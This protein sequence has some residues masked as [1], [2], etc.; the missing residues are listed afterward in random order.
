MSFAARDERI[1]SLM[2]T[3]EA[4]I[5]V[6]KRTTTIHN[7]D[8]VLGRS[9]IRVFAGKTGYIDE[10]GHCFASLVADPVDGRTK[11]VVVLG[12]NVRPAVFAETRHLLRWATASA[13]RELSPEETE[14]ALPTVE[15]ALPSVDAVVAAV[16]AAKLAEIPVVE[17]IDRGVAIATIAPEATQLAEQPE[18]QGLDVERSRD[19]LGCTPQLF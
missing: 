15:A 5:Q 11:A 1:T 18:P 17:A 19:S 16:E 13:K 14:I 6:G 4:T 2:L 8:R 9:D 12:A 10:A 7:T 3:Q